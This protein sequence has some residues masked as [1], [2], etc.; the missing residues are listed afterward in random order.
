MKYLIIITLLFSSLFSLNL[1]NN[2]LKQKLAEDKCSKIIN[3]SEKQ[4]EY[5]VS[6]YIWG[7]PYGLENVLPAIAWQESCAGLY[8]INV[9]DPSAGL[10]H[11]YIPSVMA[12]HSS[13]KN[14][15]YNRNKVAQMLINDDLLSAS[16]A[17]EELKFWEN[18]YKQNKNL[19]KTLSIE[20]LM[21]MSY[22]RGNRWHKSYK[23]KK[24][25]KKYLKEV[26]YK[27][28]QVKKFIKK[29]DI[30]SEINKILN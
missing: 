22:N 27:M 14:N 30:K 12:R 20:E 10:F 3:F 28:K 23:N 29:Y 1:N 11:A 5:I 26:E 16:E 2:H 19:Y 4:I 6:S 17:I 25:A 24:S 13:L 7:K 21:I 8:K 18:Y 9:Y 15:K